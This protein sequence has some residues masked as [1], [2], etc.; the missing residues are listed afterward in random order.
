M[1]N[2]RQ[3]HGEHSAEGVGKI[4]VKQANHM[5]NTFRGKYVLMWQDAFLTNLY[6]W[7]TYALPDCAE[8]MV[9]Y[10]SI[11]NITLLVCCNITMIVMSSQHDA[12][13]ECHIL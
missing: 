7:L 13:T 6:I 3:T 2:P 5:S 8:M 9:Y 4:H 11:G 10:L 1:E 12:I